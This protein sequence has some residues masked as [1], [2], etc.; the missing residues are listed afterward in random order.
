MIGKI[1][2]HFYTTTPS[3]PPWFNIDFH[4]GENLERSVH[5]RDPYQNFN[6]KRGGGRGMLSEVVQDFADQ[7]N[8]E[9]KSNLVFDDPVE[10]Q[11]YSPIFWTT[12]LGAR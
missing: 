11:I 5:S 6:I 2:H 8:E 9:N 12:L 10:T 1:L 4:L 3:P 7:P